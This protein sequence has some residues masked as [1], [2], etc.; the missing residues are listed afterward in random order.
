M[1][2]A[3]P[4]TIGHFFYIQEALTKAGT[5]TK[6]YLSKALHRYISHCQR[7]CKN[8]LARPHFLAEVVQRLLTA[9]GFYDASGMG[10]G[11]VWIDPN[12]TGAN[13]VWRVK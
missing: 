1:H 9:L 4:G 12:G 6:A 7:L 13:F 2:I 8:L 10:A 11:G 3:V 5:A